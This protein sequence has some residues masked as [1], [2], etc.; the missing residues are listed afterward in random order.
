MDFHYRESACVAMEDGGARPDGEEKTR[1]A[2]ENRWL[3]PCLW[4]ALCGK[5][6]AIFFAV[7]SPGSPI[8]A[9]IVA[10]TESFEN[11]AKNLWPI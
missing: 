5:Q 10:K 9:P 3:P 6:K 7:D 1:L 11:W 8:A 4:P 2:Q